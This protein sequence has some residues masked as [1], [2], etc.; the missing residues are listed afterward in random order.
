MMTT[1]PRHVDPSGLFRLPDI[2]SSEPTLPVFANLLLRSCSSRRKPQN[3]P[4]K[5]SWHRFQCHRPIGTFESTPSENLAPRRYQS[6]GGKPARR[7]T[8]GSRVRRETPFSS[9]V[10]DA[11]SPLPP[12]FL[13]TRARGRLRPKPILQARHSSPR[14]VTPVTGGT[15]SPPERPSVVYECSP[16]C[17]SSSRD[18]PPSAQT[19]PPET[20]DF[21]KIPE[22]CRAHAY[23][24]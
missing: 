17:P 19:L 11:G 12:S 21:S 10:I 6:L 8:G 1:T 22:P 20:R 24:R 7:H 18:I 2:P 4:R 14:D 5:G 9:D 3:R 16:R 23:F 15:G 13:P